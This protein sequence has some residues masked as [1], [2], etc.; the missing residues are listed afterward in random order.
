MSYEVEEWAFHRHNQFQSWSITCE[1][2][3]KEDAMAYAL[4]AS[5]PV[6]V[7]ELW[8]NGDHKVRSVIFNNSVGMDLRA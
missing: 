8:V 2:V 4:Q 7:F 5:R 3:H 6:K 1:S